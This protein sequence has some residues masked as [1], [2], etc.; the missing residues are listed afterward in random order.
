MKLDRKSFLLA[1]GSFVAGYLLCL[2]LLSPLPKPVGVAPILAT[3]PM[4]ASTQVTH[5]TFHIVIPPNEDPGLM[6]RRDTIPDQLEEIGRL[7][8]QAVPLID[9]RPATD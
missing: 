9:S 6:M 7:Q 5:R 2:L 1:A 3:G 8:K 4:L